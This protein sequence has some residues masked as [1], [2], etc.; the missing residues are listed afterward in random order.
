M[1]IVSKTSS[2][3]ISD[4]I[5]KTG[6][7]TYVITGELSEAIVEKILNLRAKEITLNACILKEKQ[8]EILT[9]FGATERIVFNKCSVKGVIDDC[10]SPSSG[11]VEK[12][13]QDIQDVT[14]GILKMEGR[15]EFYDPH[16][17]NNK[18]PDALSKTL[19]AR[20]VGHVEWFDP[21]VL[22]AERIVYA[23][24]LCKTIHSEMK[25][26]SASDSKD[27]LASEV[28]NDKFRIIDKANDDLTKYKTYLLEYIIAI[29]STHE[30]LARRSE[31]PT[32][33]FLVSQLKDLDVA[34]EH[35]KK[36]FEE[37]RIIRAQA[38]QL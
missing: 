31:T 22:I 20:D 34:I 2:S 9:D 26:N 16:D 23:N 4:P 14:F 6:P 15:A 27:F 10:I 19:N 18:I 1:T 11:Q 13:R 21:Q 7:G 32:E 12:V 28:R 3:L 17:S 37:Y 30:R 36:S 38:L 33:E 29:N 8:A 24:T 35:V 5:Q 25:N